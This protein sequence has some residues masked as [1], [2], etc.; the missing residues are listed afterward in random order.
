MKEH[1]LMRAMEHCLFGHDCYGC[2]LAYLDTTSECL[3]Q[4]CKSATEL[5]NKQKLEI[6]KLQ[7][8]ERDIIREFADKV[9][10]QIARNH[11]ISAEWMRNYLRDISRGNT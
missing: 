6:E 8:N 1:E 10:C 11:T 7:R 4:I 3:E 9:I 5:I 2:P